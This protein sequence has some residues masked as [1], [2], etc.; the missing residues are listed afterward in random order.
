MADVTGS[1]ELVVVVSDDEVSEASIASCRVLLCAPPV[2]RW[3]GKKLV[4]LTRQQC[5]VSILI[6]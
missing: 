3:P 6:E 2:V 5:N 4:Q 1:K